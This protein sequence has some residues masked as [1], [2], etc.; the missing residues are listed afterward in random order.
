MK[1]AP[2]CNKQEILELVMLSHFGVEMKLVADNCEV[3]EW[4]RK[5]K[6][7]ATYLRKMIVE[8]LKC[9]D[10]EQLKAL[11]RRSSHTIIRIMTSDEKRL[12]PN[13]NE[14]SDKTATLHIEDFFDLVDMATFSCY[15]CK[16]GEL[17]PECK[18][19]KLLHRLGVP[20]AREN[21]A[22]GECE[23]RADNEVKVVDPHSCRVLERL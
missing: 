18:H 6:C 7:S 10:K 3:V 17:V 13:M 20:V 15:L 4:R 5:L 23:Y 19:R 9:M 11:D 14:I 12:D 21:P 8:R 16:Q 2:Y 1:K 22:A